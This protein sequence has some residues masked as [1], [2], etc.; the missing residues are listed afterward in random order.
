MKCATSTLHEQLAVQPGIFMSEPKEPNFF[1]NDE[2]YDRGMVWY[3]SLFENAP[4]GALCGES[5]THYTKLPTYPHTVA[6]MRAH[7]PEPKLIYIMRHPIQR[8]VSQYIHEW[9]E[10]V[11]RCS[12]DQAVEEYPQLV[13][14]SR[15]TMQLEPYLKA[16]GPG[17]VLPLFFERFLAKP[18]EELE[19]ACRFI[20]YP[21]SP[22]W[23]ET[24][25]AQNVSSQRMR[26]SPLRDAIVN[27]PILSAI[28]KHLVP[29][30]IRDR[31]KSFWIM[32][33]RPELSPERVKQ[34]KAVFD[35]DLAL[36]SGWLGIEITCDTFKQVA[37]SATPGWT[38]KAPGMSS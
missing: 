13:A 30:S 22:R 12:I 28:R 35:E 8:L 20:G 31:A 38:T 36:L 3:E 17:H 19:R 7:L 26:R 34:L 4:P 1:S 27:T 2:Q 5:S 10:G 11:L 14:Y 37:L 33:E 21:A 15:Y 18:Q 29:Q 9:T 23:D 6:R 16:Y 32:K 25:E 24:L